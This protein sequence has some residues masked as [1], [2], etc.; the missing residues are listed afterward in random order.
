LPPRN[1]GTIHVSASELWKLGYLLF[2]GVI[3]PQPD[4]K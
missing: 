3:F 2:G 4:I 1:S